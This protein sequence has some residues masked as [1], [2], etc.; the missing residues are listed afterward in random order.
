MNILQS[1]IWGSH[2]GGYEEFYLLEYNAVYLAK[3]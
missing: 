3:S 1:R 2:T